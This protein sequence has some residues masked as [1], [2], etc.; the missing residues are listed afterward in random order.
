[1]TAQIDSEFK[2]VKDKR[3]MPCLL[4]NERFSVAEIAEGFYFPSTCICRA[5]YDKGQLAGY[6]QWCFGKGNRM[7]GARIAERGFNQFSLACGRYCPD[8]MICKRFV[9]DICES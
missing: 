9:E 2:S 1:M 5:C 6:H 8:R 3:L 7:E 4:C